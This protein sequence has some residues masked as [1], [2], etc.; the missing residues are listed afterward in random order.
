[1]NRFPALG[2]K[3][4]RPTRTM[5]DHGIRRERRSDAIVS[6]VQENELIVEESSQRKIDDFLIVERAAQ[7]LGLL[8][9]L[10]KAVE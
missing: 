5:A 8:G 6:F 1:M 2:A 4:T 3:E 7:K 10:T 9:K